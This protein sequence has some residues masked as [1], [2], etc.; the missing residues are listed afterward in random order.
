MKKSSAAGRRLHGRGDLP[1]A[2]ALQCGSFS[3][4]SQKA[5]GRNI[6]HSIDKHRLVVVWNADRAKTAGQAGSTRERGLSRMAAWG[7]EP[8]VFVATK[9]T[10]AKFATDR[11][12]SRSDLIAR[13]HDAC[14]LDPETRGDGPRSLEVGAKGFDVAPLFQ[15]VEMREGMRADLL[16]RVVE[17]S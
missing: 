4:R 13:K 14:K 17:N 6:D 7:M 12:M 8:N 5:A 1:Q 2:Q 9:G 10:Q 3:H 16:G 11:Q 15:A